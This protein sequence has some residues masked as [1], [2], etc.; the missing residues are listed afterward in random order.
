MGTPPEPMAHPQVLVMTRLSRRQVGAALGIPH[1]TV[2]DHLR[3]A[4]RAGLGW[5]LPEGMS[6][7]AL[8]AALFAKEPAPPAET[9]P[10][11]DWKH[12]HTELR[13]PGVTLM[14]LWL[15]KVYEREGSL[16]RVAE[17]YNTTAVTVGRWL[18]SIGVTLR[19]RRKPRD[20]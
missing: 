19:P 7:A 13:R 1:T 16:D 10:L 4:G 5:P 8:E 2:A 17:H 12:I 20:G 9:R 14:L 3:R 15:E 6:D 11:P 18:R